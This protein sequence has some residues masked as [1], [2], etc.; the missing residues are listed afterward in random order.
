MFYNDITQIGHMVGVVILLGLTYI[1]SIIV[2]EVGHYIMLKRYGIN[3]Q[4]RIKNRKIL[5]GEDHNYVKLTTKQY[6]NVTLAGVLSGHIIMILLLFAFFNVFIIY[7]GMTIIYF[8]GCRNDTRELIKIL[9]G[10]K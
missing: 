7:F 1:I 3:P 9:R 6:Y 10:T 2:H 5:M 8:W 4:V